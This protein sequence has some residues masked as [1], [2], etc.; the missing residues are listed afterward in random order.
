MPAISKSIVIDEK[1]ALIGTVNLDQRSFWLNFEMTMLIDA[2]EVAARLLHTQR[3]YLLSSEELI[4]SQWKKRSYFKKLL[5]SL[6][7]LFS[8][9][10]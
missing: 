7:Y 5:E 9:L 8:P 1:I 3:H 6:F 10:L 2:H 4:L